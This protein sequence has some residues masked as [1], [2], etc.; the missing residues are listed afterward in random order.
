M[1]YLHKRVKQSKKKH[2][3]KP[4]QC[5][6]SV[7]PI[8]KCVQIS[9]WY[10][11]SQQNRPFSSTLLPRQVWTEP[12]ISQF[13]DLL[14]NL[15]SRASHFPSLQLHLWTALHRARGRVLL[16][17]VQI[18]CVIKMLLAFSRSLFTHLSEIP[19]SPLSKQ[20]TKV[21]S[22]LTPFTLG[23]FS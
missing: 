4:P 7:Y 23:V 18:T 8:P 2:F 6:A 14:Y 16:R 3:S 11:D 17:D 15:S 21:P 19:E 5:C 22:V 20:G 1:L 10:C 13:R 12:Y 9:V